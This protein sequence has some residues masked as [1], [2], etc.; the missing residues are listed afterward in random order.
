MG[1]VTPAV[2]LAARVGVVVAVAADI[3]KRG[4][5]HVNARIDD[6]DDH[7]LAAVAARTVRRCA[8]GCRR[9]DPLRPAVGEQLA[10]LARL[11]MDDTRQRGQ[12]CSLGRRQLDRE[13]IE[14]DVVNI[15]HLEPTPQPF[16]RALEQFRAPLGQ[17]GQVGLRRRAGNIQPGRACDLDI[18]RRQA[19]DPAPVTRQRGVIQPDDIRAH[20]IQGRKLQGTGQS[21]SI[22]GHGRLRRGQSDLAGKHQRDKQRHNGQPC[23]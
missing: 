22:R 18:G 8:P 9:A 5:I 21:G 17:E 19:V 3:G 10:H 1:W 14:D 6:A 20:R 16:F 23:E 15:A 11:D 12:E 4:V 7:A 13:A 2:E